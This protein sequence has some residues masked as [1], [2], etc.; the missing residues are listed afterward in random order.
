MP[1]IVLG[2]EY[3]MVKKRKHMFTQENKKFLPKP[4]K[5]EWADW[6]SEG[7]CVETFKQRLVHDHLGG[8]LQRPSSRTDQV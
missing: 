1:C 4:S 7:N 8:C 3:T 2:T 6:C 5:P